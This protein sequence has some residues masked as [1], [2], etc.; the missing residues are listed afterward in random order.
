MV[1]RRRY[2]GGLLVTAGDFVTRG[3]FLHCFSAK[4]IDS[5]KV[6][7]LI[8]YTSFCK[9]LGG[10]DSEAPPE[11]PPCPFAY[12]WATRPPFSAI[13]GSLLLFFLVL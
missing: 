6:M 10:A 8:R 4:S 3:L 5:T 9:S 1:P 7:D 13:R 12:G 11:A 2:W